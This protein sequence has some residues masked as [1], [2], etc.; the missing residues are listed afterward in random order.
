MRLSSKLAAALTVALTVALAPAGA[1]VPPKGG[2]AVKSKYTTESL[3]LG[4]TRAGKRMVAVGEYGN[5]VLS[6][7]DG[8]TWRQATKVPSTVTLTA[9]AFVDE[10]TGWAVGHDTLILKTLDGGETWVKQFGGGESDNALLSVFFKSPTNGFAVGA[11]NYTVETTDA[12]KTWVERKTLMP[13]PPAGTVVKKPIDENADPTKTVEGAGGA[14]PYAAAE[15]DENHLNAIF[16]GPDANTLLI[17]A[18]AGAVYRST[19][20][21]VTW[22]K[23][24]TGYV[25]SFWGG[26]TAKDGTVYVTGMRGNIWASKDKGATFA[27]L[28]TSGADQSIAAGLQ[29]KDGSLVFVGLGGQVLYSPDGVKY[30]LT[31]RPDRKGLNAVIEDE[32]ELFVLGEAGIQKQSITPKPEEVDV[33]LPATDTGG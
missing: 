14:D 26:L 30:T 13:P 20:A 3:L 4:V 21:G 17:A 2:E 25:G 6:D 33:P 11:F 8:K 24:L 27:K 29:L 19:D 22:S 1:V 10:K 7:D 28:D 9:V 16:Q 23:I 5:I 12:G 15:G 18:E 31:Y 32:V